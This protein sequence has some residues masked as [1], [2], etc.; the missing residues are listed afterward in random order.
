MGHQTERAN[1]MTT[2]RTL[3]VWLVLA[4]R[5][6]GAE[7]VDYAAQVKPI[8]R[9]RCF[10]CHGTLNQKGGLRLDAASLILRGG[11]SGRALVPGQPAASLLVEKITATDPDSRMP[12]EGEPLTGGQIAL[13]TTWID[14]GAPVPVD[15]PIPADP[16]RH[17]AFG[18]PQ[19]RVSPDVTAAWARSEID[20]FLAAVHQQRGL[21]PV[22]E[23]NR[24][25]LLRRVYL[26]LIGLP[27]T[28]AQ[29][30]AFL[31]DESPA[32][33]ERVVDGLLASPLYGQRWARHWM[34]VWRYSDPSGYEKEIRDGRE[35]LWRWRDWIIESLN[36]DK[37]Y[38]RM[39][40]EMLAADEALPEDRGALR[41]TGFLARNWYKFNRNVWLDNIVE[42]SSKAFLGLTANCAR[43]HNHKYDP[44]TQEEYFQLRAVF[45]THDVRDDPEPGSGG[46]LVRTFDAHADRPTY[47][48]VQGNELKP[49]RARPLPPGL[50]ALFGTRLKIEPIALPVTAYYPALRPAA[51]QMTV[52]TAEARVAAAAGQIAAANERVATAR[53]TLAK[54][55]LAKFKK[56][57]KPKAAVDAKR[58]DLARVVL[59]DDF[60][61]LDRTR[62]S[63][64]SGSWEV[65]QERLVQTE[66]ASLQRRLV[67]RGSHPRDFQAS[68]TLR[69]QGGELYRS[70]GIGFDVHGKAMHAVYLSAYAGG[71]KVQVTLQ[72]EAGKWAYPN[73][74]AAACAVEL[75][76]D[77]R[78]EVRVRARRL[79]VLVDDRV[80]VAYV[81]PERRATGQLALWTFSAAGRFDD[82]RV[83]TLPADLT[84]VEPAG[85]GGVPGT[86]TEASLEA[87]L[88]D[89]EAG[90]HI[91]S[92]QGEAAEAGR[93]ALLARQAAERSKYGVD[94]GHQNQRATKASQSERRAAIADGLAEVA[95]SR[96]RVIEL[97]RKQARGAA[98]A[99]KEL[100]EAE[101]E[102]AAHAKQLN[103][104]KRRPT[105]GSDGY[106]PLGTVHPTSSSGRRLALARWITEPGNPLA[107][108]VGVN[109]IWLR[110]FDEPLVDRMFDFGLRS[111][112]PV[113]AA[114]LD[115]LAVRWIDDDWS[116]KRLH[117]RIVT[118]GAYRLDSASA[119][120][121]ANRQIDPDNRL[122]WRHNVRRMEAEVVRDSLLHVGGSLDVTGGGP[123]I[124]HNRGQDVPRRSLFFRQDKERQMMFL[125]LFDGAKVNECYR[126]K[127]SVAP[128]Q[129]LAMYNSSLASTQAASLSAGLGVTDPAEVVTA[130]FEAV[131]SRVPKDRELKECLAFMDEFPDSLRARRQLALVLLNH[132]DFLSIR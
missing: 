99:S 36:G 84:L 130:L 28:R 62:W 127:A 71:S 113:H 91:A 132:N 5:L 77:Y 82:L 68:V 64:E 41:A 96:Q 49:D 131:L 120:A 122:F 12:P 53:R 101:M 76:R 21:Q 39:V 43:C 115:W 2:K 33:Y 38:D 9:E 13:L 66:G 59:A 103:D 24:S 124:D 34:D 70:M 11:D 6:P 57:P 107:A 61:E 97:K 37:G 86:V 22:A 7:P 78:L 83:S 79:N 123:P 98:N 17:W 48:F 42:H 92:L 23:V 106:Q 20:R 40:V 111:P 25:A 90:A 50:P 110:H 60:T 94:E 16:R 32:A 55:K 45:E 73:L 58:K 29:L 51:L 93:E 105:D 52:R 119:A 65:R 67:S 126:R 74:G 54:F 114:L 18:R 81:L 72:D 100:T 89:A 44:I 14:Q 46:K 15:E 125:G 128:Q 102:G 47:L 69:V 10:A 121:P 1:R 4:C 30:H 95:R 129:A 87:A 31:G 35:H 27:P 118:S 112:R 88:Q 85:A 104:A 8:L 117:Q 80:L 19:A 26:D 108:R 63:V 56:V 109:H 116:M 3:L 75:N